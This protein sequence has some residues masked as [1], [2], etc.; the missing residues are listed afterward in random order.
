MSRKARDPANMVGYLSALGVFGAGV[1]GAAA[2][3]RAAGRS[4][5]DR[6]G[7]VDLVVGGLATQKFAR[8]VTK[9]LVT[10]PVRA[11][12]TE[13]EGIAGS[14][15]VNE[16]PRSGHPQHTVGEMISCPFCVAPWI[17]TAYVAGL[18]LAPRVARAWAAVFGVVSA[19]DALQQG[20]GRLR[21][22]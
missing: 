7:V 6:Y 18:T 8:L 16:R 12:F 5:P 22:D 20:Y 15:E 4:L 3:G 17:A 19:A 13:V 2:V 14:G 9:D 21:T 1:G 11:P 10:T